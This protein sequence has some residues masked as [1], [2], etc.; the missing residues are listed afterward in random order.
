M[1]IV[2]KPPIDISSLSPEERLELIGRLWDSLDAV[3]VDL[4]EEQRSELDRRLDALEATGPV[5]SP[6]ADVEARIR[7][8]GP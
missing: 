5:G 8:R 4:T 3:Q 2:K 1:S 7:S 6:W